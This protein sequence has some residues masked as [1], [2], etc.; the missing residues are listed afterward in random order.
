MDHP[1]REIA[2][3]RRMTPAQKLAVMQALIQQAYDLKAAAVRARWPELS[4]EE[5]WAKTR[6]QVGGDC[7]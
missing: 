5:V 6:A 1:D 2:A 4:D 3:L 7:P